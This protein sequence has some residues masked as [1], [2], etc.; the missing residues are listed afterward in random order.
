[1]AESDSV[2][3]R[4]SRRPVRS[5]R[6]AAA[7][8][9][10]P[11]LLNDKNVVVGHDRGEVIA[12]KLA[13]LRGAGACAVRKED[14]ALADAARVDRQLAGRRMRGVVL[15]VE[16]RSKVAERNPGRLTAPAAVDE[17]ALDRQ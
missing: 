15:V 13:Y 16:A 5:D 17:L 11:G 6:A 1:M 8:E 7:E 3:E 9:P 4:H 10:V 2:A 14:L 12:G